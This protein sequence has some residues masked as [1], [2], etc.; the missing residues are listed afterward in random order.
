MHP[1]TG[2]NPSKDVNLCIPPAFVCVHRCVGVCVCVRSCDRGRWD[3]T[4]HKSLDASCA[5]DRVQNSM[6]LCMSVC[7]KCS[8]STGCGVTCFF[9]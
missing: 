4:V 9:F 3:E 1:A 8:L 2:V 7:C 5:W 6:W